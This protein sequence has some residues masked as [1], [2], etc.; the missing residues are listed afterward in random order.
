RNTDSYGLERPPVLGAD[1]IARLPVSRGLDVSRFPERPVHVVDGVSAP[2]TCAQ[3]SKPAGASTS[4]LTLLS[5][6]TL[7]L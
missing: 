2:V 6:S 7:P 4:S 5:G 3:W 1:D